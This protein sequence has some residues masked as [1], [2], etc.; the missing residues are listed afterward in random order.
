VI[1]IDVPL[2]IPTGLAHLAPLQGLISLQ[3]GGG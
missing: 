2:L 1:Y 3:G